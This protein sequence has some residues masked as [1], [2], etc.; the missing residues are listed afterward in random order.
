MAKKNAPKQDIPRGED[1]VGTGNNARLRMLDQ[2]NDA[3]DARLREEGELVDIDESAEFQAK[4]L[5]D[6]TDEEMTQQELDR[7]AA[8]AGQQAPAEEEDDAAPVM[9]AQKIKVKVNGVE[10]ELTL[11][12]VVDLAQKAQAA[13][14]KFR[15]AARLRQEAEELARKP[16]HP[17][18]SQEDVARNALEKRRA[19]ARAIQMGTEEEA[20]AAIEQLQKN[21]QPVDT[22]DILKTVDERLTFNEAI[23]RFRT[24]Y[25]DI[26]EDPML[27]NIAM[28]RDQDLLN[29]GDRR[30]Y[31]ERYESIGKELRTWLAGKTKATAPAAPASNPDK[32]SRKASAPAVPQSTGSKA[33]AAVTEDEH[34]ETASE[35][36]S[37]M[38]AARGG[39]QFMR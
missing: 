26:V 1:V 31:W 32:V 18:P 2:I 20:V 37:K 11:D 5:E 29:S 16:E 6:L 34:E 4:P 9:S 33:P 25:K 24:E 10:R 14:E 36:I 21:A 23:T 38:A 35:I 30:S 13:D 39:P 3:N 27:L 17:Q 8:E 15:E 22:A 7:Y 19:L 28:R 12:E